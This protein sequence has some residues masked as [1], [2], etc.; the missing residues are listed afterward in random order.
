M[1]V[2]QPT[3]SIVDLI[4]ESVFFIDQQSRGETTRWDLIPEEL[5]DFHRTTAQHI[6]NKLTSAGLQITQQT[7][8]G[9]S[10]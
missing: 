1:I 8:F 9:H 7:Q 10:S 5:R 2:L 4:A 6:V 3:A